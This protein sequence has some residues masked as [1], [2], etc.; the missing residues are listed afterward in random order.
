MLPT[1]F[2]PYRCFSHSSYSTPV[3]IRQVRLAI[4]FILSAQ[5]D[6]S[7]VLSAFSVSKVLEFRFSTAIRYS[8]LSLRCS[9]FAAHDTFRRTGPS[10]E[11]G[12]SPPEASSRAAGCLLVEA[13]P[14]LQAPKAGS[15]PL[16]VPTRPTP[17]LTH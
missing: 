8:Y 6:S 12:K 2:W 1:P 5:Q 3:L 9:Y 15:R 11:P 13:L 16:A 7:E 10:G 14:V 4:L 17:T